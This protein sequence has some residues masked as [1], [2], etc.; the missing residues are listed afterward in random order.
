MSRQSTDSLVEANIK[1]SKY[2]EEKHQLLTFGFCRKNTTMIEQIIPNPIINICLIYAFLIIEYFKGNVENLQ[3]SDDNKTATNSSDLNEVTFGAFIL[4]CDE[5]NT[6]IYTWKIMINSVGLGITI[7]VD[8]VNDDHKL[9]PWYFLDGKNHHYAYT[10]ESFIF[11]HKHTGDIKN[12]ISLD[13][14]FGFSTNDIITMIIDCGKKTVDFYKNDKHV[15]QC[16]NVH[17]NQYR[18][19]IQLYANIYCPY[20]DEYFSGIPASVTLKNFSISN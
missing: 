3:I 17:P 6:D 1:Y 2:I 11:C 7:G 15:Y 14:Q 5:N 20:D 13:D 4:N 16:K 9:D 18:L 10:N 12:I 8:E 19:A